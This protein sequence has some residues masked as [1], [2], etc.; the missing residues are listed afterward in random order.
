MRN[1]T[2]LIT[3]AS[4]GIG[5]AAAELFAQ[6]GYRIIL[7]YLNSEPSA[8]KL[9]QDLMKQGVDVLPFRAD[10]SNIEQVN[11]MVDAGEARFGNID[12]LV[13][14][15]GRSQQKLFT[16]ITPNEWRDMMSVTLDAAYYCCRAVLPGMI[17]QKSGKIVLISSIWGMVGASC[18]VHYSAA[19]AAL[20]GMTKSLSKELGP[21]NIQV[22]CVAPG[23][24]DT[25]MNAKLN[26]E[27]RSFLIQDTPLGRIGTPHNVAEAILFLSSQ[28][29][30]FITGQVLSPN[31]GFV[32]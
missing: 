27:T 28:K 3:G 18:E 15:A 13:S 22:N 17:R 8:L 5:K 31:G 25:D 20:I 2:V 1:R 19:K 12:V 6:Q 21:S 4:R 16:E 26:Q 32:I 29:S 11:R 14:N 7:N 24:I 9:A 10:V 30:D 23:I